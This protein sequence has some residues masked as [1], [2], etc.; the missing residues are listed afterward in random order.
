MPGAARVDD[1]ITH[2]LGMVSMMGGA[3]VGAVIGAAVIMTAPVSLT[4]GAMIV[5]GAVAGGAL[6]MKQLV[7]GVSTVKDLPGPT[8]GK[9]MVGSPNVFINGKPAAVAQAHLCTPCTGSPCVH[10]RSPVPVMLAEGSA[11]VFINGQPAVR[12]GDKTMCGAKIKQ[13]SSNVFIGGGTRSTSD[14]KDNEGLW[15]TGFEV[16]GM[17]ALVGA[18]GMALAAGIGAVAIFGG[19]VGAGYSAFK[20]LGALGNAIGPGYADLLQ[21]FAGVATLFAGPKLAKGST[22]QSKKNITSDAKERSA[23][24]SKKYG[25]LTSEQRMARIDELSRM[26]YE[27]RIGEAINNQEY[28]DIY[29][30]RVWV[31]RF[32]KELFVATRPRSS[33]TLVAQSQKG[34]KFFRN[35][36]SLNTAWRFLS[37]NLTGSASQGP[38]G[39]KR[40][41]VGKCSPTPIRKQ[42]L[43]GSASS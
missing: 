14:I 29:L 18:G 35:G 32:E 37:T 26:N 8:T 5:G 1:S 23:Y 25:S 21:G 2:G 22:G 3:V 31:C 16:V 20:G 34:L 12:V 42:A 43:V 36:A 41:L 7:G 11:T 30:K 39:T 33:P 24:L 4:V 27:R 17:A 38:W 6:S 19:V 9:V 28:S 15:Q 40:L 10:M 13:G